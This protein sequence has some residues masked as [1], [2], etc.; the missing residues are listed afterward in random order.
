LE[1]PV[2]QQKF[3][4][5]LIEHRVHHVH[6]AADRFVVQAGSIDQLHNGLPDFYS[7]S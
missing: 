5:N 2:V 7:A 4:D 1:D 3:E 6:P